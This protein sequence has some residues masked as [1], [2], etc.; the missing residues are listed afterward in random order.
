MCQVGFHMLRH[1][2]KFYKSIE[3]ELTES[4]ES[5]ES[6]CYNV[7]HSKV[8]GDDLVA[9]AFSDMWN[10][11]ISIVSPCYKYPVDLWHNKDNPEVVLIANGGSYMAHRHKTTHF[12]SSRPIDPAFQKPG[13]ELVNKTVGIEPHLVFKKLKPV[14]LDNAEQARKMALDEYIDV[15]KEKSLEL[16]CGITKEIARLDRHIASLIHESDMKKEQ[17]SQ[18]A[19]KLECLGISAEKIAIATQQ[20]DLP[21]MITDEVHKEEVMVSRKRK[22]EE[23]EREM[24]RKKARKEMIVMKDGK[25]ITTGTKEKEP[26][27][28]AEEP[29]T[30]EVRHNSVLVRQ[31]QGI[32]KDQ[33][34]LIQRQ[35]TQIIELN[36]RIKQLEMEKNELLKQQSE[37]QPMPLLPSIPSLSNIAGLPILDDATLQ[38]LTTPVEP[39]AGTS[40]Q[41]RTSFAVEKMMKPEHLKFLPKYSNIAVKKEPTKGDEEV[42]VEVPEE[43]QFGM[44]PESA[45]NVIYIPKKSALVLVPPTQKRVLSKRTNPG[46]PVPHDG[47][48]PNRYY[49]EN[50]SC[51]YAK[52]P[53]L[54]KHVKYMCMKTDFDYIC[55]TC[56]KGF[57]TDYGVREHYY[58]EHKK[59]HLYFCTLCGKG[60]FHKSKKSLHKKGCPNKGGEEK[61]AARAPYDAELELTFKRRQ[62]MEIEVPPEVAEIARQEEESARAAEQ[63]EEE[64]LE[65]G[66]EDDPEAHRQ[67]DDDDDTEESTD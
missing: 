58:Q 25:V 50:C 26:D 53:D 2:N 23:E 18:I 47:H 13:R 16:L 8:W 32:M 22:S 55:D 9:A 30:E 61:F 7:Y 63:L 1:P 46:T 52:K 33:E 24:K 21:Y 3:Q 14:I 4:G 57:H 31:Q 66:K 51:N 43:Q 19:Y 12:S 67:K 60:F 35:D 62:R 17:R 20:K 36:T 10:V 27:E 28:P 49:C 64:E 37:E 40:S 5:Y 65:K 54:T 29:E 38:Q 34:K 56:Q 15:E 45:S 11:A 59:E 6:Y 41:S 42:V 39:V 48:D 44:I